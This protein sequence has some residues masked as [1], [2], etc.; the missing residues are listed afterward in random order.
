ME[1]ELS[2]GITVTLNYD[3]EQ[4]HP[5]HGSSYWDVESYTITHI[6]GVPCTTLARELREEFGEEIESAIREYEGV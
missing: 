2:N 5:D 4:I 1:Y 6:D 3:L